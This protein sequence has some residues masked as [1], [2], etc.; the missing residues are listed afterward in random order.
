GLTIGLPVAYYADGL[1]A[2]V[3][4]AFAE[5][6]RVLQGLGARVIE[7]AMPDQA[8]L[9][10]MAGLVWAP[11]AAALHLDWLRD[12]PQDYGEQVRNRLLHGLAMPA[13]T[14]VRARRLRSA[15]LAAMLA[16]PLARCDI[17][18]TPTLRMPTP[19]GE[20]AGANA[21]A[22]MD[23]VVGDL[24]AL[25]RPI[26]Y[27]GL[28]ALSTPMGFDGAGLP[29]GLQLIGAPRAESLL[30]GAAHAFERATDWLARPLPPL[31]ST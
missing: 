16:G 14:Y 18:A 7:V 1:A 9:A 8:H 2:E 31:P 15:D 4:A 3:A 25:T 21:G 20:A 6:V 27:L 30:L 26:S 23:K 22:A 19:G 11:E 10:A 12:R 5:A 24:S 17:L 13:A 29:L 28:P